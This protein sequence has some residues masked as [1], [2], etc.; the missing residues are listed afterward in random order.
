[1]AVKAGQPLARL[2]PGRP[3]AF[4]GRPRWRRWLP[5]KANSPPPAASAQR[6]ADLLAKR[7][8]SQAAFDAKENAFRSARA[9]LEQARAQSQISGNQASYGTLMPPNMMA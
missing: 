8:V 9:R 2:D 1:M 7:F 6:Y 5:R 3:A 4:A